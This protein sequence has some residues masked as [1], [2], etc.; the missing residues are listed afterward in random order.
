MKKGLAYIIIFVFLCTISNNVADYSIAREIA[1][2][3]PYSLCFAS[4]GAIS[5]ASRMDCW[6][7][8]KTNLTAN[9]MRHQ[10]DEILKSLQLPSANGHFLF[11]RRGRISELQYHNLV[12]NVD[13]HV[14]ITSNSDT[15]S[16][17][18]V[19]TVMAEN[20][21]LKLDDKQKRLCNITHLQWKAYYLYS[22]LLN[23]VLNANAQKELLQVVVKQLKAKEINHYSDDRMT[24][25]TAFS[26]K[27]KSDTIMINDN[28]CNIQASVRS[29]H[30]SG[31]SF[32]Y[33]GNPLILGDY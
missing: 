1:E 8:L 3:S 2:R 11:Q 17:D 26:P 12:D 16:T 5:L 28:K 23:Q 31:K 20:G 7:K 15:H 33:I 19:C 10:L 13:Y 21:I 27:I 25:I 32:V 14:I 9:E 30:I 24:G 18:L 29:D 4:I 6:A 22:G